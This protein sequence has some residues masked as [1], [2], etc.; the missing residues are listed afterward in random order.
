LPKI[1]K[2][3]RLAAR[4]TP[5]EGN[6][7]LAALIRDH[8]RKELAE[9]LESDETTVST[10][11][12]GRCGAHRPTKR[13]QMALERIYGLP[14]GAWSARVGA[15]VESKPKASEAPPAPPVNPEASSDIKTISLETITT[16]RGLL[17]NN[18]PK[19]AVAGLAGALA[20]Q[21]EILAKV[22]GQLDVSISAILRSSAWREIVTALDGVL[23]RH[24]QAA[25][26]WLE[27]CRR[28]ESLQ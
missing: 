1:R 24:P 17:A 15:V 26:E 12:L 14:R 22:T 10:W 7:L 21:Q 18:P 9:V 3:E 27:V 6:R 4:R 2:G 5:S 28:W 11:G 23:E 13:V 16:L 8:G 19:S 25:A 20:K